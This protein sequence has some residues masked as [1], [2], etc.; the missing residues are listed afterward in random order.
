[1]E[2]PICKSENTQRLAVAFVNGT[3][4][5]STTSY[6]TGAGAGSGGR[7]G[8]GGGVTKTSGQSQSILAQ[9]VA[10]PVKKPYKVPFLCFLFGV[11]I[12]FI[13]FELGSIVEGLVVVG[14]SGYFLYSRF[15]FNSKEWPNIYQYWK[16][17][18]ICHKCGGTYHQA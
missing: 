7:V 16:E 3:H 11:L 18:W 6:T 10:P 14:I 5:I 4:N 8:I 15:Q 13:K 1:M 9:H 2:C 17:S 12:P